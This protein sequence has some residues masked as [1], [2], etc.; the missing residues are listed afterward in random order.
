MQKIS[1]TNHYS[2]ICLYGLSPWYLARIYWLVWC[3][4]I[5]QYG[6][7]TILGSIYCEA[8]VRYLHSENVCSRIRGEHVSFLYWSLRLLELIQTYLITKSSNCKW[9][10]NKTFKLYF[11]FLFFFRRMEKKSLICTNI[12]KIDLDSLLK[13]RTSF[14]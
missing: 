12:S 11:F 8:S 9:R 5:S 4:F 1:Y 13:R 10:L 2:V 7:R 3:N 6:I 14:Q